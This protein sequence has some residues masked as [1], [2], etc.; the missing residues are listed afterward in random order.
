MEEAHVTREIL[1]AVA[2]GELPARV[3][4]ELGV[5]HLMSL[6]PVCR[7]EITAFQGAHRGTITPGYF[8]ALEAV[9]EEHEPALSQ[10]E[11]Q[12]EADI[13]RLMAL[14]EEARARAIMRSR[15]HFRSGFFVRRLIASSDAAIHREPAQ[16]FHLAE[17]ARVA[18]SHSPR[19]PDVFDLIALSSASMGNAK[20]ASGLLR[21]AEDYFHHA[22][23]FAGGGMISDTMILAR[24]DE[25]EGSLRKDQRH[26]ARAHELFSRAATLYRMS[27]AKKEYARVLVALADVHFYRGSIPSALEGVR[28]ALRHMPR[29]LH[30]RLYLCARYNL[31][32]YLVEEGRFTD[33][34]EIL[35]RDA[36]LYAHFPEP[37]T[38]L[39]L[40]W[41]SGKIAAGEGDPD[42]AEGLFLAARDGF[43]REGI[44]FDAAMVIVEDLALLYLSAGRLQE[45]KHLAEQASVI[46][47]AQDV[48]REAIAALMLFQDAARQ[49][50]L[51][52]TFL[53]D[54]A[55]YLKT[56]RHDPS[57]AFRAKS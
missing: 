20:R 23:G 45:V 47:T 30:S 16:A 54:L 1:R 36:E 55:I 18:A 38:Q 5:T 53:Q 44:G 24:I 3:L 31:T 9:L 15:T 14:P 7:R 21:D 17:L 8:K 32:R 28:Y 11:R 34:A 41:I 12:A 37:W 48:H 50:T 52:A 49:E 13:K 43:I 57:C 46:F 6:C 27:K 26:F 19:L 39:R 33:A 35:V 4:T 56:T 40:T 42:K 29:D 51:T 22:R 2:D 25:L 10:G